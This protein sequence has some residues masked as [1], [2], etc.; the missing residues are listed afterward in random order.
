MDSSRYI[1]PHS[2][3]LPLLNAMPTPKGCVV[4]D[5]HLDLRLS[6]DIC[7]GSRAR[8]RG[9]WSVRVMSWDEVVMSKVWDGMMAG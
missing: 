3:S 9:M 7:A 2:H 6:F 4:G 5:H 8:W 1:H